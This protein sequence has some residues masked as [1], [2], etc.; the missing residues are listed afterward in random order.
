[1]GIKNIFVVGAGLMGSGIAQVC[2]QAGYS[3]ILNDL[4][5]EILETGIKTIKWSV[6]K[7]IE[8]EKIKGNTKEI[9]ERIR[10]TTVL[11]EAKNSDFVFEAIFENPEIK[12]KVFSELDKIC[13]ANTIFA[14]NTSA[15]P[16]TEI[17]EATKRQEKVIGTHFFSPVPMM[18]LVEIIKGLKTSAETLEVAIKL[19]KNLGKEAVQ[20]NR[21]I[22]GFAL[23][24]INIPST[25]E[26]INLVEAGV[27]SIEDVDKGLKLGFGRPM[28]PFETADMVGLDVGF[29][30]MMAIY[31]ETGN[32][33]FMPPMLL[34]RKVKAGQ[35]GRKVGV[36]WYK[37]EANGRKIGL[38][39]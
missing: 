19:C 14:S 36:G 28:G 27:I 9:M 5:A 30:A 32:H 15:I 31:R 25:V 12:C 1:M 8:K 3:V 4:D 20:V 7:L 33:K 11:E 29:N 13:I 6:S 24:R 21:D 38:A 18:G 17:A 37:Y 16:I 34:Q 39:D 26:A 22:A 35:L 2:A 23:N 10:I